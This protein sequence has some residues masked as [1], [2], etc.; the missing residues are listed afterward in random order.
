MTTTTTFSKIGLIGMVN[1]PKP[2]KIAPYGANISLKLKPTKYP[3]GKS[4]RVYKGFYL[5]PLGHFTHIYH[6][7]E[8]LYIVSLFRYKD[9]IEWID[10]NINE[11]KRRIDELK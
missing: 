11:I 4:K 8:N 10:K 1:P 3:K 6:I 7:E 2:I 5:R 9:P